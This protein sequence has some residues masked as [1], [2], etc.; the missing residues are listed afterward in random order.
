MQHVGDRQV[1]CRLGERLPKT[2]DAAPARSRAWCQRP[3]PR[4]PSRAGPGRRPGS[5]R[6]S[7]PTRARRRRRSAAGRPAGPR[8]RARRRRRATAVRPRDQ[9]VQ[10]FDEVQGRGR[11]NLSERRGAGPVDGRSEALYGLRGTTAHRPHRRR[12]PPWRSSWRTRARLPG[13]RAGGPVTAAERRGRVGDQWYPVPPA[14]A[15]TPCSRPGLPAR[16]LRRRHARRRASASSSGGIEVQVSGLTSQN[17]SGTPAGQLLAGGRKSEGREDRDV[18]RS[19]RA[20]RPRAWP[21]AVPPSPTTWR[22]LR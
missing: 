11:M 7:A 22:S 6:P 9:P 13:S 4:A 20:R 10:S 21:A 3:S 19:P 12:K 15:I 16:P 5:G 2:G 18:A 17:R 8:A 1:R 14:D